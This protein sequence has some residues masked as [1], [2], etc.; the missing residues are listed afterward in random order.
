M[1][2]ISFIAAVL[3]LITFCCCNYRKLLAAIELDQNKIPGYELL[4]DLPP[5]AG[6]VCTFG[7]YREDETGLEYLIE[8][9]NSTNKEED[10]LKM[11]KAIH[12][13]ICWSEYFLVGYEYLRS[14]EK[15]LFVL[16]IEGENLDS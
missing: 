5:F 14:N 13:C 11:K 10:A 3:Y 7:L 15:L 8:R 16:Q 9:V 1:D 4:K 6:K 2:A 12:R